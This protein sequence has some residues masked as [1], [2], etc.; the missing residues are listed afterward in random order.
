MKMDI[1]QKIVPVVIGIDPGV[2]GRGPLS[3]EGGSGRKLTELIPEFHLWDKVNLHP[4]PGPRFVDQDRE[5]ARNLSGM[6]W[7]RRVLL[8]GGRVATAFGVHTELFEW[9]TSPGFAAAVVPHPSG[10]SRWWNDP[11]NVRTFHEFCKTTSEPTVYLEGPDGAGKT[12]LARSLE[13]EVTP[14]EDPPKSREECETRVA[15]RIAPGL[16]CD[17][18]SGLVSELVYG[19]VIRGSLMLEEEWAWGVLRAVSRCSVFVHCVGNVDADLSFRETE[20]PEH[21]LRV[22][23]RH[24]KICTSYCEVFRKIRNLGATV[25]T[26]DWRNELCAE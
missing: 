8:L 26:Y 9:T 1:F 11:A 2:V 17:R 18:F 6:L 3:E 22:R 16:L 19:P 12:T 7:G 24:D 5:A 20:D 21:V 15:R 25:L 4:S 23:E 13:R 14:S 10:L